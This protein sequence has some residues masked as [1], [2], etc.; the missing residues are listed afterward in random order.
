MRDVSFRCEKFLKCLW[1]WINSVRAYIIRAYL[2]GK[3]LI[4]RVLF[5]L[6]LP[7][8]VLLKA[9]KMHFNVL[10]FILMRHAFSVRKSMNWKLKRSSLK[11]CNLFSCTMYLFAKKNFWS[12]FSESIN[13]VCAYI[14]HAS[15]PGEKKFRVLFVLWLPFEI[16]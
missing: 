9:W 8:E 14:I 3:K 7:F 2:P 16:L 10:L 15:L 12:V 4:S 13:S 11:C 1:E 6:P 5:L